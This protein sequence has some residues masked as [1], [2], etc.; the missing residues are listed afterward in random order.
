MFKD[1]AKKLPSESTN[2]KKNASRLD[3]TKPVD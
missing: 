2:K 1:I 3:D